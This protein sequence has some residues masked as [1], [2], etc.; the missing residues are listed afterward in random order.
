MLRTGSDARREADDVD[1][2]AADLSH[3]TPARTIHRMSRSVSIAGVS[4]ELEERGEG[5]PLLFLHP[6]EGLQLQRDWLDLLA[7][8]FRVIA[9]HHPGWG[10]SSLPD[11][12]NT[13][14]D[15]AYLYLDLAAT[16]ALEKAML[17]GACFG[18]WI[19]AE[20]AVRD[21]RRFA[22][23]VLV[24][25]LGIKVGGVTDRDIADMH[26]ISREEFMRLAWADPAKGDRD[27]MQMAETELAGIARGREAL[28]RFG[29]KPYMHNPHLKR[30][31]HRID[32]PTLLLWGE[33][34]GIVDTAYG[35]AF[36]AEIPG[37]RMEVIAS[38][39]HFPHWE[40]P[41]DF[42]ERLSRFCN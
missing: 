13:V 30:W 36:R 5:S 9:P 32:I 21:T 19:A 34:D 1:T 14:D 22:R 24:D 38:A 31:L 2:N 37:A 41:Q 33:R 15:L 3:A 40:Q 17:V 23:L 28:A 20:M 16:L 12:L 35:E 27:M 18:G 7:Q 39:G 11:W 10:N 4:I 25:P 42:A 26:A 6:G 29:W 8:R